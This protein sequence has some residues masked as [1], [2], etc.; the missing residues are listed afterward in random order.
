[1]AAINYKIT[2]KIDVLFTSASGWTKELK[3]GKW[4]TLSEEELLARI[5]DIRASGDKFGF[6]PQRPGFGI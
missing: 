1:M 6:V 5:R 3:M 2:E 4:V